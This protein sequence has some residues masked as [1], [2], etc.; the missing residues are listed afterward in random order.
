MKYHMI[1]NHMPNNLF[2]IFINVV[3]L[4]ISSALCIR[5]VNKLFPYRI[6]RFVLLPGVIIHE[7]SHAALCYVFKHKIEKIS[8][9]NTDY[10]STTLGFVSHSYNPH[11]IYQQIG[12]FFI[13]I[14]PIFGGYFFLFILLGNF[15]GVDFSFW[16]IDAFALYI[17]LTNWSELTLVGYLLL[18]ISITLCPSSQDFKNSIFGGVIFSVISLLGVILI[19]KIGQYFIITL[20]LVAPILSLVCMVS[21]IMLSFLSLIYLIFRGFHKLI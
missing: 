19:P 20:D 2:F 3:A 21:I 15:T 6:V 18:T 7:L 13:A 17:Q 12:N 9:L 1:L 8:F 5:L 4:F 11:S 14:A 16:D 10:T